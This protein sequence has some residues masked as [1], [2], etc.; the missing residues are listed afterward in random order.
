MALTVASVRI[1][2]QMVGSIRVV[3]TS[4]W[5]DLDVSTRLNMARAAPALER[6]RTDDLLPIFAELELRATDPFR[7]ALE[8]LVDALDPERRL[9]A[10]NCDIARIARTRV[11]SELAE[12]VH[13]VPRK[14][15]IAREFATL[16]TGPRDSAVADSHVHSGG[17]SP[18][19]VILRSLLRDLVLTAEKGPELHLRDARGHEFNAEPFVLAF[20][21]A[22]YALL[23][24]ELRSGLRVHL[25]VLGVEASELWSRSIAAAN[26]DDEPFR[27]ILR[28]SVVVLRDRAGATPQLSTTMIA[29]KNWLGAGTDPESNLL[30][31]GAIGSL[32]VLHAALVPPA[33]ATLDDF[34]ERFELLRR[35]RK[36]AVQD[37]VE[38]VE[39]SIRFL[40]RGGRLTRL[41]L[42][43]TAASSVARDHG[44]EHRDAY[45][46]ICNDVAVHAAA[47]ERI[48][49]DNTEFVMQMPVSFHR[50]RP[51]AVQPVLGEIALRHPLVDAFAVAGGLARACLESEGRRDFIGGVDVV[52]RESATPNWIYGMAF[53][54]LHE[55]IGLGGGRPLAYAVHAGEQFAFPLEGLRRIGE[56][57]LFDVTVSRVGHALALSPSTA[58]C[59][60][61]SPVYRASE[62]LESLLWAGWLDPTL[63]SQNER[64]CAELGAIVFAPF[65]PTFGELERW[66]VRRFNYEAM[67]RIGFARDPQQF[68]QELWPVGDLIPRASIQC[69]DQVDRM[70][71]AAM[72]TMP[73][74][75]VGFDDGGLVPDTRV[76]VVSEAVS[77]C[78]TSCLPRVCREFA[79][80]RTI[81][82]CPS[83]NV[84]LAGLPGYALHPVGEFKNAGLRVTVSTDD[85]GL[86]GA[87]VE[88]ELLG[89]YACGSLGSGVRRDTWF[90]ELVTHSNNTTAPGLS[91]SRC[92]TIIDSLGR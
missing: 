88:E 48:R 43:K 52:G 9:S 2:A 64:L 15:V 27:E 16:P 57:L 68:R 24:N 4:E 55:A 30:A 10:Q 33:T 66:F 17:V 91:A 18:P 75:D 92:A 72:T 85:P 31:R 82:S 89:T 23:S 37:E 21:V 49:R 80:T 50:H 34:V 35:M 74:D 76:D 25:P 12:L 20:A 42:R 71:V 19:I 58:A 22:S 6:T 54:Y 59:V 62:V 60:A 79:G 36:I 3:E 56:L 83:S 11:P 78:Y 29:A 73:Y 44:G 46:D 69:S 45:A 53:R 86:F 26:G 39:D 41:E 87:L 32:S 28:R 14:V 63:A 65:A 13:G 61:P 77:S 70:V 5:S 7:A 8:V 84:S 47:A 51:P 1:A 81:E 40:L 90:G 67:M 38:R